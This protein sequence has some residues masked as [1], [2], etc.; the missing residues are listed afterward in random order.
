M[1]REK[2][3]TFNERD[4]LISLITSD[5][6][7]REVAPILNSSLAECADKSDMIDCYKKINI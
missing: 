3:N 2:L 6:F 1:R 7:C 4:L 5:K